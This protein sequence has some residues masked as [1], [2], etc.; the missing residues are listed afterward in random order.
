MTFFKRY[1]TRCIAALVLT[2]ALSACV[3][4]D[5]VP[6]NGASDDYL[7]VLRINALDGTISGPDIGDSHEMVKSLR[8]IMLNNGAIELNRY[9]VPSNDA[10]GINMADLDYVLT[11]KTIEGA[12]KFYLFANEES[13]GTPEFGDDVTSENELPTNL[14][15]YL[16]SIVPDTDNAQAG[17]DFENLINALYFRPDYTRDASGNVYLPYASYYDG[18]TVGADSPSNATEPLQM[19]LVPV[20]TKF[21]FQFVNYRLS[22]VDI[23]DITVSSTNLDNYLLGRVNSPDN[24]KDFD[25]KDYYWVDW[26]A[27]VSAASHSNSDYYD[28]VGFN[29]KYGWI[30]NYDLPFRSEV[31]VSQFVDAVGYK[32]APAGVLDVDTDEI[33]PKTLVLGPYYAPESWNEYTYT[34][35]AT[36][37]EVT[38]QRYGLTLAL[39]DVNSLPESD[40]N[41]TNV[42]IDNLHALFRNTCVL[43]KVTM[44]SGP[45]EVYAEINP[46]NPKTANGWLVEGNAPSNNPFAKSLKRH[47]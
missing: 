31:Q 3:Y 43:I 34:D 36:K 22:P 41:F 28:N 12:K 47:D 39:H 46:W 32:T 17:Q 21:M 11:A 42:A 2:V 15:A 24:V 45:V 9:V 23:T 37:Q 14:H 38:I 33:T 19:Y 25:G 44:S 13:V 40:P 4:E 1:I 8:I 26:L 30:S 16:Q 5:Y 20:A 6:E 18:Y 29:E 27:R 7:I 35:E 10:Q